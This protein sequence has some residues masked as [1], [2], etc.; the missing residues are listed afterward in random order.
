MTRDEIIQKWDGMTARERDAQVGEELFCPVYEMDGDYFWTHP[1]FPLCQ[2]P[3]YTSDW[4]Q[5]STVV[6]CMV[7]RG[8]Y[9]D[10]SLEDD[11]QGNYWRCHLGHYEKGAVY[12]DAE[13]APEAICLA[14]ILAVR[15]V[16]M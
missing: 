11:L 7:A 16:E 1:D 10:I 4:A 15:E 3:H 2:V 12:A 14:A 6:E 9:P 8:W 13:T 5:A